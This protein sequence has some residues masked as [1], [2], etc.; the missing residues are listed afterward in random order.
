MA[1]GTVTDDKGNPAA[2]VT[3]TVKGSNIRVLTEETGSFTI[4]AAPNSTLTFSS[5]NF[6]LNEIT[7]KQGGFLTVLLNQ[8][9]AQ[10]SDVV[11]A[12]YLPVHLQ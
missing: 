8:K 12:L 1:R 2:G 10:L 4:Q 11:V 5:V 9:V 7:V 6:D 3:V